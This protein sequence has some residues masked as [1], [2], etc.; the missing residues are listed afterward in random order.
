MTMKMEV[1]VMVMVKLHS[2]PAVLVLLLC[3]HPALQL[4]N[5]APYYGKSF[6]SSSQT[7]LSAAPY[8]TAP[9]EVLPIQPLLIY[10]E[11]RDVL[12]QA[13]T[14]DDDEEQDVIYVKLLQRKSGGYRPNQQRLEQAPHIKELSLKDI[15]YVKALANG[16]FSHERLKV[17]RLP[18]FY[19][20]SVFRNAEK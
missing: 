20:I 11:P 16:Q 1:V 17:Y 9:N 6:K 3:L 19:A 10:P 2:S 7:E 12:F 8:P 18:E 15:F 13:R 4:A 14:L 5:G